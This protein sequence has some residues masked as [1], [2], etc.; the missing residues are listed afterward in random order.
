MS[1]KNYVCV[2]CGQDFTRKYSAYRHSRH[3]H[4]EGGKIVRTLEYI[5]G[6]IAGK[7]FPADPVLFRRKRRELTANVGSSDFPFVNVAHDNNRSQRSSKLIQQKEYGLSQEMCDE[8]TKAYSTEQSGNPI[9]AKLAEYKSLYNTLFPNQIQ[10]N[11]IRLMEL[12]LIHQ[13]GNT[14]VLDAKLQA[15]RWLEAS[16]LWTRSAGSE[17]RV[18]EKELLRLHPDCCDLPQEAISK[19]ADIRQIMLRN[20]HE[21]IAFE[22]IKWLGQEY[23]NRRSLDV[24]DSILNHYSMNSGHHV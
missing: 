10:D 18:A 8:P 6:R 22:K 23:R 9:S 24:L 16:G 2:I 4:Q 20:T 1:F 13:G 3:L 17:E 12:Y 19:L 21:A 11:E 14:S 7:Y 5:T 15:L